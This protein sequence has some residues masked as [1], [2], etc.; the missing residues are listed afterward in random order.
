MSN[1]E[2]PV[3]LLLQRFLNETTLVNGMFYCRE[4][5]FLL[6]IPVLGDSI[7]LMSPSLLSS[8]PSKLDVAKDRNI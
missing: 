4:K 5:F 1:V 7:K 6:A 2:S 3:G 8:M